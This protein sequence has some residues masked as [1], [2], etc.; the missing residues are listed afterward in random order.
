MT[1]LYTE[2]TEALTIVKLFQV[3]IIT[4]LFSLLLV[5]A[6]PE[7]AIASIEADK[8]AVVIFAYQRIG[9]DSLP[10]AN[11][12]L[13]LFRQHIDELTSGDYTVLPLPEVIEALENNRTL[14][15]KTVALTFDG[16]FRSTYENA[17][18]LLEEADLP[19]T[20]FIATDMADRQ[21][22][23]YMTWREIK[24]LERKDNVTIGILP[25]HYTDLSVL[26]H[27]EAT[28]LINRAVSRYREVFDREPTFFA[29]PFGTYSADLKQHIKSYSFKA[30]V[31]QQSGVAHRQSDY[32]ALPRFVMTQSYGDLDRFMLTSNALPLPAFD[33]VPD[34]TKLEDPHP[35][36]GFTIT[37]ELKDLSRLSCFI[38]GHGK[39][40]IN[41]INERVEIRL[42]Q[43]LVAGRTRINCT[44]PDSTIIPG[45]Q[46]HWRWFGMLLTLPG[47]FS[48]VE[49]NIFIEDSGL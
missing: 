27:T 43:P 48:D 32:Y 8:S 45:E 37:P 26:E 44:M 35:N 28:G 29:W 10:Q 33:V 11:L 25:A 31:G 49:D 3:S 39:A 24:S 7:R 40:D 13:E 1:I 6:L 42:D 16:A 38:S 17:V 2:C 9:E 47:S 5:T 46:Q 20:L 15:Q 41:K 22:T 19:Y 30:A 36:I 4:I 21:A 18:P 14:P 12:T 23:S 34:S